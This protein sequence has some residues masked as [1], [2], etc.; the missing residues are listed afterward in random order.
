M[1][2][3]SLT[4]LLS[5]GLSTLLIPLECY[6][7]RQEP[8]N[9]DKVLVQ[10]GPPLELPSPGDKEVTAFTSIGTCIGN[11]V[12]VPLYRTEYIEYLYRPDARLGLPTGPDPISIPTLETVTYT[13]EEL[14]VTTVCDDECL[15]GEVAGLDCIETG[16]RT[17]IGSFTIEVVSLEKN[18]GPF[19]VFL[20]GPSVPIDAFF[21]LPAARHSSRLTILG[22]AVE[23]GLLLTNG[24]PGSELVSVQGAFD[25]GVRTVAVEVEMLELAPLSEVPLDICGQSEDILELGDYHTL[26]GTPGLTFT[27]SGTGAVNG[28]RLDTRL[29]PEGSTTIT[30]TAEGALNGSATTTLEFVKTPLPDITAGNFQFTCKGEELVLAG[31]SPVGGSWSSEQLTVVDGRI[32]TQDVPPGTYEVTYTVSEGNCSGSASKTIEI[33]PLPFV[34][35]GEDIGICSADGFLDLKGTGAFPDGG[36][37]RAL[38]GNVALNNGVLNLQ[39]LDIL[40]DGIKELFVEYMYSDASGCENSDTKKITVYE[41]PEAPVISQTPICGAGQATLTIDNFNASWRYQWYEGNVAIPGENGRTLTT[42]I[43]SAAK[44]YRVSASNPFQTGCERFGQLD[45]KITTPPSRPIVQTDSRC[46]SGEVLLGAGGIPNAEYR[47]YSG[48]SVSENIIHI[49][50]SY[51]PTITQT[52]TYYVSAIVDGC[53]GEKAEVTATVYFQP[54]APVVVEDERCGPGEVSLRAS[55]LTSGG[56]YVWYTEEDGGNPIL[57]GQDVLVIGDLETT[58][59]YY[60]SVRMQ[61][62]GCESERVP[63]TATVQPVPTAPTVENGYICGD[64]G[65]V[66]LRVNGAITGFDYEW[67]S[68]LPATVSGKVG[69]GSGLVTPQLTESATYYV[70]AISPA[71]CTSDFSPVQAIIVGDGP[72]D[73]GNDSEVCRFDGDFDLRETLPASMPDALKEGGVFTGPGVFSGNVF[74]PNSLPP[75]SYEIRYTNTDLGGCE[76]VGTRKITIREGAGSATISLPSDRLKLCSSELP[77]DLSAFT[78]TYNGG[79]FSTTDNGVDISGTVMGET[80]PGSYGLTYTVVVDGCTYTPSLEVEVRENLADA[81]SVIADRAAYCPGEQVLLTASG[82]AANGYRWYDSVNRQIG[83]GTQLRFPAGI[84]DVV[85]VGAVDANGCPSEL[86][87]TTLDVPTL[88]DSIMV[89]SNVIQQ[90]GAVSFSLE[91]S[92]AISYSW[93]FE[94]G[95]ANATSAQQSPAYFFNDAGTFE[96]TVTVRTASGC[97]RTL[98]TTILVGE[99]ETDIITS[100]DGKEIKDTPDVYPNPFRDR[101]GIDNVMNTAWHLADWQLYDAMGRKVGNGRLEGKGTLDT[102]AYPRGVC[103]LVLRNDEETI[104]FKLM[105][106]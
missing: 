33:R 22:D 52:T 40:D 80:G 45:L 87:E 41:T 71:G 101:L 54:P 32:N 1:N 75:G 105:K 46:G 17:R 36:S 97:E 81:P 25:N 8:L 64:I 55:G 66:S 76:V 65:T 106:R 14:Y 79:S 34:D 38:E 11:G 91:A 35:A 20:G 99:S 12:V 95:K 90:Y 74:S 57:T 48:N 56:E 29:L 67:Y 68:S 37:W 16:E 30:V 72:L 9:V 78:G 98:Y 31:G 44:T 28:D 102:S 26:T 61:D 73:I 13:I 63:V 4:V 49:G 2:I 94:E 51:S 15:A 24:S 96:V 92:D 62:T 88:P 43:L 70:H 39:I 6:S 69:E 60:V 7:Q 84:T 104:T 5:I 85:L 82:N 47:W 58:T 103:L 93:R 83:E 3:Y 100:T 19:L 21:E 50:E 23:D 18:E 42:G 77:I 86:T 53:E 27:Y 10:F 59:D 89:S